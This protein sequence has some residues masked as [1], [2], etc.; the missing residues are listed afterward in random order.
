LIK[1][2]VLFFSGTD[3]VELKQQVIGDFL[4]D[5]RIVVVFLVLIYIVPHPLGQ[6]QSLACGSLLEEGFDLFDDF[7]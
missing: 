4:G 6:I 7:Q 1:I 5:N 2:G 3:S